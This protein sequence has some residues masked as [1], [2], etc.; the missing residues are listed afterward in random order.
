VRT[1]GDNGQLAARVWDRAPGTGMQRL[2][3]RGIYRLTD[4]QRGRF[5]FTLDGNGWK[6]RRGHRIFV[7]LLGRDAPTYAPSPT[8][9]SARLTKV[10]V[11]VPVRGR[12]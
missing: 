7:E 11:S 1:L 5:T 2:I 6:F 4:G 10:R 9:F 8:A 12:P 3:T